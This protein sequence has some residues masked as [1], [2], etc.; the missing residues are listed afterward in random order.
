[1]ETPRVSYPRATPAPDVLPITD[2]VYQWA[3]VYTPGLRLEPARDEFLQYCRMKS[4]TNRDW[5]EAL[6]LW[7]LKAYQRATEK[8]ILTSRTTVT[9]ESSGE[10]PSYLRPPPTEE[11]CPTTEEVRA[12]V[13]SFLSNHSMPSTSETTDRRRSSLEVDTRVGRSGEVEW[14]ARELLMQARRACQ[15]DQLTR[16]GLS[17]LKSRLRQA[18]S[19][20]ELTAIAAEIPE[21]MLTPG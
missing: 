1:M 20:V 18:T 4:I 5:L 10:V 13:G 19:P 14:R 12:L 7:L 3:E 11:E 15:H 16:E 17:A 21:V 8:G 6:K 2:E 9:G